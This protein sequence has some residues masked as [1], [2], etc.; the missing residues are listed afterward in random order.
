MKTISFSHKYQKFGCLD[1]KTAVLL[2]VQ[3]W[4]VTKLPASFL[5]Y[6]AVYQDEEGHD[7]YYQLP[8]K[9]EVLV[10]FFWGDDGNR[11]RLL[12][13]TIRSRI[14]RYG[15]DKLDYYRVG[16]TFKVEIGEVG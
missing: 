8:E 1:I 6:D 13:T 7:F 10:L 12:F 2:G 4:D 15:K 5:D 14:S 11:N 16:E 9:G 3:V